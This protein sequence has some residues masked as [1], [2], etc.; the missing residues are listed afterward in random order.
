MT[1][2]IEDGNQ[3]L[4]CAYDGGTILFDLN[5]KTFITPKNKI[6]TLKFAYYQEKESIIWN[7]HEGHLQKINTLTETAEKVNLHNKAGQGLK[8][9]HAVIAY[10]NYL[11][12]GSNQ[13]LI[14]FN[15]QEKAA[16]LFTVIDG[17]AH[18]KTY[19]ILPDK[20]YLWIGTY[21]G[22]SRFD[23][24]TSTFKNYNR[25]D[26]I[27]HP[28]F[29]QYATL[30]ASNG[31][32]YMGCKNGINAFH[33][34]H[35]TLKKE[36][37]ALHWT[38]FQKYDVAKEQTLKWQRFQL[39]NLLPLKLKHNDQT[40][41]FDFALMNLA[42]PYGNQYAFFLENFDKNW[43]APQPQSFVQYNVLPPGEYTLHIKAFDNRGNPAVNELA[44]PIEVLQI[45]YKQWW[46]KLL[47]TS[48]VLGLLFLGYRF[49]LNRKLEQ[50]ET[51]RIKE[52]DILKSR[53]YTNITHEFRTP[54]TVILG[55]AEQLTVGSKQSAVGT[56]VKKDFEK[57]LGMINRNGQNLLN[58]VNQM[59]DLSKLES[60]EMS[61][62]TE[63]WRK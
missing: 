8:A 58:L 16:K 48:I 34:R 21:N 59:L 49:Q 50:E 15:P 39:T 2:I 9:S 47:A 23:L 53:L 40:I 38:G 11:W 46:A 32:I 28:Q 42:Q 5:A 30:K 33:P 63:I 62:T 61:L 10:Q 18:N 55:M 41:T 19:S 1:P 57:K 37:V 52:M 12:I 25:V 4:W 31:S 14:R 27:T 60:G 56:E 6:P 24:Q 7:L 29:N 45:W 54:L 36:P 3:R 26:G 20:K 35:L 17:L 44:I 43:Q 13:G 51:R 22:I